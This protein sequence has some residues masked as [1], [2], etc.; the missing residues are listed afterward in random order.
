VVL[1]SESDLQLLLAAGK[2]APERWRCGRI[3]SLVAVP[4]EGDAR[5][6]ATRG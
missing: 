2:P 5:W 1:P 6:T 4:A 3:E